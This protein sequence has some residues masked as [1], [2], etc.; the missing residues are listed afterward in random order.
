HRYEFNNA[1]RQEL[2]AA[3]LSLAGLSPDKKLVEIVELP[4]HPW[5][6]GVQFHP[7]FRSRPNRPHPLFSGFVDA[8]LTHG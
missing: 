8:A 1:F 4:S 6:V 5:F 2:T 7:E 3:G